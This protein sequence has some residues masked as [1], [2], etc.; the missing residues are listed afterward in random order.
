MPR[1]HCKLEQRVLVWSRDGS[2][3]WKGKVN[4]HSMYLFQTRPELYHCVFPH[5]AKHTTNALSKSPRLSK[6]QLT[7]RRQPV[8]GSIFSCRDLQLPGGD[9]FVMQA[10]GPFLPAITSFTLAPLIRSALKCKITLTTRSCPLLS[11]YIKSWPR[12]G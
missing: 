9:T 2:E 11:S 12:E 5:Q 8:D 7:S 1:P 4:P 6:R 10:N 3:V